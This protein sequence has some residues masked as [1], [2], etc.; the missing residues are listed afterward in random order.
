MVWKRNPF[1]DGFTDQPA[2]VG[3]A[4]WPPVEYFKAAKTTA[5][6]ID[7]AAKVHGLSVFAPDG[8]TRLVPARPDLFYSPKRRPDFSGKLVCDPRSTSQGFATE[9][10]VQFARF[11]TQWHE[12]NFEDVVVLDS[13]HAGSIGASTLADRTRY[14]VHDIFEYADIVASAKAFLVTEAGG[15]SLAAAIR[16]AGTFVL[17]TTRAF[18]ERNFLWPGNTYC[19]TGE[20][21]QGDREWPE[22]GA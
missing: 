17:I 8:V 7:T 6:P 4:G 21:T 5:S 11:I 22:F 15:Q 14:V 12:W 9:L 2:N 18:N 19:V 3:E 10:F 20:M 1:V 16:A 13:P